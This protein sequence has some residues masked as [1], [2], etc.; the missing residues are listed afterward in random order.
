MGDPNYMLITLEEASWGKVCIQ[1]K[2]PVHIFVFCSMK[3]LGVFLLP[4]LDGMLI[5]HRVTPSIKF[6]GK[7]LY[8]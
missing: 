6:A 7:N 3:P 8:S 4:Q 5:H 1:A 2:W